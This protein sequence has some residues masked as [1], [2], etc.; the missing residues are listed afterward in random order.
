MNAPHVDTGTSD[1]V[2]TL[3]DAAQKLMNALVAIAEKKLRLPNKFKVAHV[4]PQADFD[5]IGEMEESVCF[6]YLRMANGR[7]IRFAATDSEQARLN[8]LERSRRHGEF[9]PA[10]APSPDEDMLGLI[11]RVQRLIFRTVTYLKNKVRRF[12]SGRRNCYVRAR[13]K[14]YHQ[15]HYCFRC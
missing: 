1:P 3:Q 10:V 8:F 11:E 6:I 2:W 14:F 5:R 13:H 9:T 12:Q 15:H 7:K 4:R